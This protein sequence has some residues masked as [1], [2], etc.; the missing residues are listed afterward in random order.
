VAGFAYQLIDA[1]LSAGSRE[2]AKCCFTSAAAVQVVVTAD[3]EVHRGCTVHFGQYGLLVPV[4]DDATEL[5]LQA[6]DWAA[7]KVHTRMFTHTHKLGT[8][9]LVMA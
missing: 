5:A 9:A 4:L 1:L 3:P 6:M 8:T 7:E 2:L